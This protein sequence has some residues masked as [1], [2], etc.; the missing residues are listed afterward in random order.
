MAAAAVRPAVIHAHFGWAGRD[1]LP[2]A[3]RL[4]VPLLVTFHASDVLVASQFRRRDK[5]AA[6]LR[7]E[8]HQHSRLFAAVPRVVAVSEFIAEKVRDAGFDRHIDV[9]PAGVRLERFPFREASTEGPVRIAFVGRQV[10]RKGLDVLLRALPAVLRQHP[11]VSVSV[12]GDGPEADANS[13]LVRQLG[14]ASHVRLLGARPSD[15]V[16]ELLHRSD[17]LVMCSRVM[18]NGE[19]EGSPVV[20]KEA[21]ASGAL[22]V[23]TDNGGT[24]E[25]LPPEFRREMVPA[26]DPDALATRI[27][28]LIAARN[29]WPERAR[30][31]RA[32]VEREFDWRLLARRTSDV[33]EAL[34]EGHKIDDRSCE[35]ATSAPAES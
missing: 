25:T 23:A 13:N 31:G 14:I 26:N 3:A 35:E 10:L 9:I 1:A 34:V 30:V 5:P 7:G 19:A 8:A 33:Y 21:L 17:I 24:A 28:G 12:V 27:C 18:P 20:T 29:T 2:L 22:V 16:Q 32:Y 11:D 15:D 4:Q 6:F